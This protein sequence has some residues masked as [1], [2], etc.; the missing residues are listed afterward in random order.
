VPTD[1]TAVAG[2]QA[3]AVIG[4][5]LGDQRLVERLRLGG[6]V[7]VSNIPGPPEQLYLAGVPV[8]RLYPFGPVI[9]GNA[10]NV[11]VLSYKRRHL[12][13]GLVADRRAVPDLERLTADLVTAFD[14]L[15]KAVLA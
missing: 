7:V 12:S 1:L 14:E 5:V 6:N 8:E 11:T 13:L 4:R 3:A 15:G 10:L 9:E 2:P